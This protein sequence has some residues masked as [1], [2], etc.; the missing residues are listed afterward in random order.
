[1]GLHLHARSPGLAGTAVWIL[2]RTFAAH[3]ACIAA[4]AECLLVATGPPITLLHAPPLRGPI[5][6]ISVVPLLFA[7][8]LVPLG[9]APKFRRWA[10]LKK[11]FAV[12]AAAC[13]S[14][15]YF[16]TDHD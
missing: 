12:A 15:A 6:A 10:S 5:P 2:T 3:N 4:P 7:S 13:F 1:M 11:R 8:V 16:A 14:G 9:G